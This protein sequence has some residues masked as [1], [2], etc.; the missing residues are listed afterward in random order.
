MD[1]WS[2]YLS[3]YIIIDI[4]DTLIIQPEADAKYCVNRHSQSISEIK[5]NEWRKKSEDINSQY[6]QISRQ[7]LLITYSKVDYQPSIMT[8]ELI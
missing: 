1:E 7:G 4:L 8:A 2:P 3:L 5:K 6:N